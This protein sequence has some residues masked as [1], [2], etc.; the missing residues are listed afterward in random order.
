M[1]L[2]FTLIK[3]DMQL[4]L[5]GG[6]ASLVAILFY[7]IVA[8]LVPLAIGPEPAL[9]SKIAAGIAWLGV[10]LATLLTLEKLFQPDH[11]DGS[12]EQ[13]LV[14]GVSP[15]LLALSRILFHWLST[16]IP[17]ILATPLVA[18]LL[19]FPLHQLGMLMVSLLLG[20]PGLSAVGAL[21]GSLAIGV[22]RAGLLIALLIL[23]L[24]IPLL[25]FGVGALAD[26][27]ALKLLAAYSLA[28]V[29]LAPFAAGAAI[30]L[31][32]D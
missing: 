2:F 1:K 15:E 29:A 21:A 7:L 31:A 32:C 16:A 24:A 28:A 4:N 17:L 23:P 9:L 10:L 25:I 20:T 30:R 18:L 27:A 12:L 13:Y 5:R 26:P 11:E 14:H 22:K 19:A 8:S 6:W 3:R